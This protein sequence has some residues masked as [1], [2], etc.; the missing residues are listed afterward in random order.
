MP[1]PIRMPLE[2]ANEILAGVQ[3]LKDSD[4]PPA[5]AADKPRA[6]TPPKPADNDS[7]DDVMDQLTAMLN[8]SEPPAETPP[9]ADPGAPITTLTAAAEKLGL[10]SEQLFDLEIAMPDGGE[11]L[12]LGEL[13]DR[14][15][16]W[17]R[18]ALE[19]EEF[20][21]RKLEQTNAV[22]NAR[23]EL[24]TLIAMLPANARTPQMLERARQQI[25]TQRE[26]QTAELLRR[27]PEWKDQTA[28]AADREEML[29]HIA[30]HGF[31]QQDFDQVYDARLIA[32]IRHNA[33]RE[34]RLSAMLEQMQA[35]RQRDGSHNG[36]GK[37]PNVKPVTPQ[38]HGMK[39][40]ELVATLNTMI[41]EQ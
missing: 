1:D 30:K 27:V 33:K 21:N 18:D 39:D 20:D 6:E 25:Q 36:P 32:Y 15:T 9:A 35:K 3:P 22:E 40:A 17:E 37:K 38:K 4:V 28:Y 11:S 16:A 12:K 31:K 8:G 34:A 41:A 24:A 7:S 5:P 19:R 13:K 23:E 14:A 29:P 26:T 10:T 2:Q